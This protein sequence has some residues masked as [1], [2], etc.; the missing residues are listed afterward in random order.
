MTEIQ[1][2]ATDLSTAEPQLRTISTGEAPDQP[3]APFGGTPW[4]D[5]SAMGP[6]ADEV[7]EEGM[8]DREVHAALERRRL[9][10]LPRRGEEARMRPPDSDFWVKFGDMFVFVEEHYDILIVQDGLTTTSNLDT[11][12]S[13]QFRRESEFDVAPEY[14]TGM[15]NSETFPDHCSGCPKLLGIMRRK[16]HEIKANANW[17][18]IDHQALKVY[19][20]ITNIINEHLRNYMPTSNIERVQIDAYRTEIVDERGIRSQLRRMTS[21]TREAH[22]ETATQL[23]LQRTMDLIEEGPANKD[24]DI[25]ILTLEERTADRMQ[26]EEYFRVARTDIQRL[27]RRMTL[28]PGS[29]RNFELLDRAT[30]NL[31]EPKEESSEREDN[32]WWRGVNEV[33]SFRPFRRT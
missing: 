8:R 24:D 25:E 3:S 18:T 33:L 16:G 9:R 27:M 1:H 20:K 7:I 23:R 28:L 17:D 12:L 31:K 21:L 32:I 13:L 4:D 19:E 22:E 2:Y 30:T 11:M 10:G 29:H 5:G 14:R 6:R 15:I 26:R